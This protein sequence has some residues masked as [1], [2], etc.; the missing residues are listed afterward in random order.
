MLTAPQVRRRYHDLH[1]LLNQHHQQLHP[2]G[3]PPLP[4]ARS[5]PPPGPRNHHSPGAHARHSTQRLLLPPKPLHPPH[6]RRRERPPHPTTPRLPR[7]PTLLSTLLPLPLPTPTPSHLPPNPRPNGD[8][9]DPDLPPLVPA[10]NPFPSRRPQPPSLLRRLPLRLLLLPHPL[11]PHHPLGP[12]EPQGRRRGHAR[13]RLRPGRPV[14]G[15][16]SG[17]PRGG[18][19]LDEVGGAVRSLQGRR[20]RGY[21]GGARCGRWGRGGGYESRCCCCQAWKG[22]RGRG[23]GNNADSVVALRE[24]FGC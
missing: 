5:P 4:A 10:G 8:L 18:G 20:V 9:P 17:G 1:L 16:R 21:V 24:V 12:H 6:P 15:A 22:P 2:P 19:H 3:G 14:R 11:H 23:C 13:H 7:A